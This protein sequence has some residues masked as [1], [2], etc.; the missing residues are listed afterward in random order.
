MAEAVRPYH[1]IAE[2]FSPSEIKGDLCDELG[3]KEWD[4]DGKSPKDLGRSLESIVLRKDQLGELLAAIKKYKNHFDPWRYL[5]L[6]VME[7]VGTPGDDRAQTLADFCEKTLHLDVAQLKLTYGDLLGIEGDPLLYREKALVIQEAMKAAG[8]ERELLLAVRHACQQA[9]PHCKVNLRVFGI[10]DDETLE[11]DG[12]DPKKRPDGEKPDNGETAVL[13][14]KI[15]YKNFDILISKAGDDNQYQVRV[16]HSPHGQAGPVDVTIPPEGDTRFANLVSF[17]NNLISPEPKTK[18]L[19]KKLT[20]LLFPGDVWGKFEQCFASLAD[21]EG[22]RVRLQIEPE[23][24]DML[25]WEYCWQEPPY[26]FIFQDR[27]ATLVRYPGVSMKMGDVAVELPLRI[28]VATAVPDGFDEL[29]VKRELTHVR[30]GLRPL[31][32]TGHAILDVLEK[33]SRVTLLDKLDRARQSGKPYHILHFIGHGVLEGSGEGA[34]ALVKSNTDNTQSNLSASKFRAI[35]KDSDLKLVFLNACKTAVHDKIQPMNSIARSL[36]TA[37]VPAVAAMQFNVPDDMAILFS[38]RFYQNLAMGIPLDQS[39]AEIRRAA[40]VETEDG[41]L[42]GIL[43]FLM[44]SEDGQLWQPNKQVAQDLANWKPPKWLDGVRHAVDA[45]EAA[46]TAV[47][48]QLDAT[49]VPIA[50]PALAQVKAEAAKDEPDKTA[51]TGLLTA[52]DTAVKLFGD[53]AAAVQEAVAEAQTAVASE[54]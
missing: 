2:N 14:E 42:W 7:H 52:L 6:F 1:F 27:R 18:E 50:D 10:E 41:T 21:G 26:D 8:R 34:L 37:E 23:E 12:A 5:Y 51:L 49:F 17:L 54:E 48:P 30:Q 9:N 44:R 25:P 40:Y 19:G 35:V 46:Y 4:L 43:T 29:D 33:T 24:L 11:D 36:I 47:K 22:L 3:I 53:A 16:I 45:I 20:S 28:L 38:C 13:P 31:L 15:Q 39:I 32:E